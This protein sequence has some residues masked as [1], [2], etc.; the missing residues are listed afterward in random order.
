MLASTTTDTN[1]AS[2]LVLPSKDAAMAIRSPSG[3]G[4]ASRRAVPVSTC[5]GSPRASARARAASAA[6]ACPAPPAVADGPRGT[7]SATALTWPPASCA[8]TPS[9][10]YSAGCA[11]VR[12][13]PLTVNG[14]GPAAVCTVT[15]CPGR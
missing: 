1:P 8:A 3:S 7:V 14:R 15:R 9:V 4:S 11:V 2:P 6:V 13:T 5:T 10:A 12:S